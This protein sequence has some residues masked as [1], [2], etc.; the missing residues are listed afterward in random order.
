M[1]LKELIEAVSTST[2][3]EKSSV[4][5]VLDA[6]FAAMSKQLKGEDAVKIQGFGTLAKKTGKDGKESRIVFRAPLTKIQK[7]EKKKKK[8]AKK[9]QDA[10]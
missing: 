3:V 8:L 1:N 10:K 4:T 7:E 9:T 2:G 5:K 6:A